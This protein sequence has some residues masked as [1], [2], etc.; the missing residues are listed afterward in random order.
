MEGSTEPYDPELVAVGWP[1][2]NVEVMCA[3]E[4]SHIPNEH[5]EHDSHRQFYMVNFEGDFW[6][7]SQ[8]RALERGELVV[9]Q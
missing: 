7:T 6:I 4:Q 9:G 3:G 5:F 2:P 1:L 8:K